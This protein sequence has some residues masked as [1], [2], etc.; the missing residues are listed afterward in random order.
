MHT[1]QLDNTEIYVVISGRGL[2]YLDGSEF[3]VGAGSMTVN[4]PG[5]THGLKNIGDSE[6]R[7][8]VIEIPLSK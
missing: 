5:G 1:H 8:V 3:E 4:S 6:L 2:M 7:L